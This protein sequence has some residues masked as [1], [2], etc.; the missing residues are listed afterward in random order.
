MFEY[1]V[2][3]PFPLKVKDVKVE[4]EAYGQKLLNTILIR[5]YE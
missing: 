4:V 5:A 3:R 2:Q 1:I